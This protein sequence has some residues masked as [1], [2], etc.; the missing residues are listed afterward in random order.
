MLEDAREDN[1]DTDAEHLGRKC[2]PLIDPRNGS[3]TYLML[4]RS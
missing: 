1:K 2:K 3:L 4:S